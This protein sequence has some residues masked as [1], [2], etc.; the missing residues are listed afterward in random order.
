[1]HHQCVN[2]SIYDFQMLMGRDG[3]L[4]VFDPANT[5]SPST[6]S[7]STPVQNITAKAKIYYFILVDVCY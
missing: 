7:L 4:Y 5:Y 3:Q 1:M 6:D 2:L